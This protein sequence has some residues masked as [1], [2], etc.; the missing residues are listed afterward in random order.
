MVGCLAV[1]DHGL[2]DIFRHGFTVLVSEPYVVLR[3]RVAL[4]CGFA[5]PDQRLP[6]IL[7]FVKNDAKFNLRIYI[8][9]FGRLLQP[10]HSLLVVLLYSQREFVLFPQPALC[11]RISGGGLLS[12]G[13]ECVRA[14]RRVALL[15]LE[16]IWD[17][18]QIDGKDCG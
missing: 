8:T 17:R 5:V 18:K 1:P 16:G 3:S 15:P 11:V 13:L 12:Q 7:H 10:E 6:I 4:V 9:L 2:R 14:V